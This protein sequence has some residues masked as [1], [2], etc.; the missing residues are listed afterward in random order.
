[1]P[2]PRGPVRVWDPFVH[3]DESLSLASVGDVIGDLGPAAPG[4]QAQR[5]T[6]LPVPVKFGSLPLVGGKESNEKEMVDDGMGEED[7]EEEQDVVM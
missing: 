4:E 2:S 1:M 6:T 5:A 7:E 3:S